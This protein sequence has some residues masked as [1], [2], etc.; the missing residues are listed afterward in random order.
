MY[1]SQ[2]SFF[3]TNTVPEE[4]IKLEMNIEPFPPE[5]IVKQ[6]AFIQGA[7]DIYFWYEGQCN[8][9][10]SGA[11]FMKTALFEPLYRLKQDITLCL[12][13]LKAW[14]FKKNVNV[15]D[16]SL[17]ALGVDINKMNKPAAKCIDSSLFFKYC[18][19]QNLS[20]LYD[21]LS[22]V[23]PKKTWLYNLSKSRPLRGKTV[24]DFFKNKSLFDRI[25]NLDLAQAYSAMQYI[26][27]YYLIRESVQRGLDK[28]EKI[29]TIAFVLPND[30]GKY[31][32]DLENDIKK[33]LQLDFGNVIKGI[34]INISF[35]FFRYTND[36]AKRPYSDSASEAIKKKEISS[37]FEYLPSN[38][39]IVTKKYNQVKK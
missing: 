35:R 8:L 21:Y 28:G 9:P 17:S 23:L 25:Q 39:N 12:Y 3:N 7:A 19:Q 36:L 37:Y 10:K 14:N 33:M 2:L 5:A 27:A 6:L 32:S 31:Y 1:T 20:S 4:N 30:E 38:E 26:E 22:D 24:G 34:A 11:E 29:I 16:M 13:S 15:Q 18:T